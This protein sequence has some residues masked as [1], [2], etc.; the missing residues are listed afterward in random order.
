[1][2][3]I[4]Y[5]DSQI[6]GEMVSFMEVVKQLS[7]GCITMAK[8]EVDQEL[9]VGDQV[10]ANMSP[11]IFEMHDDG[12]AYVVDGM[13]DLDGDDLDAAKEAAE[14]CPVDAILIDE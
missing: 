8:V 3:E 4:H 6:C 1:M 5:H 2:V 9:C 13:E 14:A 12:L 7:N 11:E 10:C